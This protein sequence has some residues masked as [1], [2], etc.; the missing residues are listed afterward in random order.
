MSWFACFL[1]SYSFVSSSMSRDGCTEMF[2]SCGR[3]MFLSLFHRKPQL[4]KSAFPLQKTQQGGS[5][6]AT[7]R[8]WRL[9]RLSVDV[10]WAGT[11]HRGNSSV[12][13]HRERRGL[14]WGSVRR[15]NAK[16]EQTEILSPPSHSL[17]FT[18]LHF[19]LCLHLSSG[20]VIFSVV[21]LVFASVSRSF[22]PVICRLSF[23]G[24]S[25][26]PLLSPAL[27]VWLLSLPLTLFL[28]WLPTHSFLYAC[29]LTNGCGRCSPRCLKRTAW[30]EPLKAWNQ[31]LGGPPPLLAW[32]A[33]TTLCH[34]RTVK[35]VCTHTHTHTHT[36]TV[37][38]E[39]NTS[40]SSS[41]L[42]AP[43]RWLFGLQVR[44]RSDL[45]GSLIL[46]CHGLPSGEHTNKP[47][48]HNL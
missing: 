13:L 45:A 22:S 2:V 18:P 1:C 24:S 19:L 36:Y 26:L 33:F 20:C 35:L 25:C 23:S 15:E 4:P 17:V 38:S 30:A 42:P 39:T 40:V 9:W 7:Q 47:R 10:S 11:T 5:V 14:T 32:S 27:L 37:Y 16:L 28:H 46:C 12:G 3:V 34:Q 6:C 21:L 31:H 44:S 43:R 29:L 48:T 41:P 8:L